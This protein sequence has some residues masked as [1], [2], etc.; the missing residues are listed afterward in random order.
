MNKTTNESK[1]KELVGTVVG[2][3][4]LKTVKVKI[5]HVFRHPLYQKA[6]VKN[7]RL[8]VHNELEGIVVGDLVRIAETRPISKTKHFIVKEKVTKI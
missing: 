1:G 7:K 5:T 3:G 8:S 2:V 6:V 4:R